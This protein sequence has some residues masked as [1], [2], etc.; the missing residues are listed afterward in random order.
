M[1]R[2]IEE[3]LSGLAEDGFN[4]TATGLPSIIHRYIIKNLDASTFEFRYDGI[5]RGGR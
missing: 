3:F 2:E 4:V 5:A 1:Q